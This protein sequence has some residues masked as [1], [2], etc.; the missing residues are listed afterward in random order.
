MKVAAVLILGIL[1]GCSEAGIRDALGGVGRGLQ[2]VGPADTPT[3]SQAGFRRLKSSYVSGMNRI[4]VYS[5]VG[6][7]QVATVA[8]VERCPL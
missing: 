2:S 8:S 7:D 6:G 1:A 4:C 5:A 3:P